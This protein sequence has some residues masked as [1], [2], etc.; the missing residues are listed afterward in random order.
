MTQPQLA[1][2]SSFTKTQQIVI[3]SHIHA[4]PSITSHTQARSA[5]LDMIPEPTELAAPILLTGLMRPQAL[6]VQLQQMQKPSGLEPAA[7]FEKVLC[8][9]V[10]EAG[11]GPLLGSVTVAA[12]LL[13]DELSQPLSQPDDA[14]SLQHTVLAGLNDSKKLSVN[15]REQLYAHITECALAYVIADVPAVVIDQLNILQATM[16][17]MQWVLQSM[18][19]SIAEQLTAEAVAAVQLQLLVDGNRC[20]NLDADLL[21]DAG[22]SI[23]QLAMQ[24]WVK[25]DSKHSSIAAASILA[26]VSRDAQMLQLA[27]KYPDYAIERHKGYPTKVHLQA[28]QSHGVLPEHRRSFAPVRHVLSEQ[29]SW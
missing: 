23:N 27:V 7:S 10:D 5:R 11:R 9:G 1:P 4:L 29:A 14:T 19:T 6:A 21:R 22:W 20:P 12:V 17:G 25:G 16:T 15:K 26:K 2:L 18:L 3:D 28:L 24:A 8:I 13:P